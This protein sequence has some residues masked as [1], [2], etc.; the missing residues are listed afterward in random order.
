MPKRSNDFQRLVYLVR[1]NLADG[2]KVTES[3]MM[4][5]RLTR[6]L[7]EVDVVIEGKVGGQAVVVSIECRDHRRIADVTWVDAMKAKHERLSTNALMLASRRGFTREAKDVACKYGI[8]LFALEDVESADLTALLAP[9]SS[10]WMK[11]IEIASHTV[12]V[13]VPASESLAA[14]SFAA[15]PDNLVYLQDGT[16]TLQLSEVVD[17]I[18]KGNRARDYLLAESKEEHNWCEFLLMAPADPE[19]RPLFVKKLE[20][21]MLRPIES[22]HVVGTCKVGI[23]QFGMRKGRLGNVEVA[24]GKAAVGGQ[25]ALAVVNLSEGG[26]RKLSIK[27]SAPDKSAERSATS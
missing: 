13:K 7:R 21:E 17:H 1:L 11:S 23:G 10:L 27:L 26:Q 15:F 9:G 20:P 24:W 18:V 8:E 6:R 16:E 19:G 25:E 22:L 5:D 12:R 3:T 2:A 4:R 14:E